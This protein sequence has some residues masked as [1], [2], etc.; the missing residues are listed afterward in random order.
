MTGLVARMRAAMRRLQLVALL[1]VAIGMAPA[2]FAT[3]QT[4]GT[5][6]N[7][8][9]AGN[10]ADA[11]QVMANFNFILGCLNSELG[12][13]P[14]TPQ[15]RLTLTT[16][17]PVMTTDVVLATTIYYTPYVGG[18]VPLYNGTSFVPTTGS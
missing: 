9:T 15:G 13:Y 6:P 11:S 1:G 18:R 16:Q 8:L 10:T 7:N 3:A 4:C 5:Y 14:I 2:G 17:R 12:K